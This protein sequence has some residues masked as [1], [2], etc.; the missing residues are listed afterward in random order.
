MKKLF[1]FLIF[2][3]IALNVSAQNCDSLYNEFLTHFTQNHSQLQTDS[4]TEG[5][6]CGFPLIVQISSNFEKFDKKQQ[7]LI[8]NY[9][10]RDE[11][12]TSIISPKGYFKIHFDTSGYYKPAYDILSAAKAFDSV[13][14]YEINILGYPHPPGD[15]ELGGDNRYD[16]YIGGTNDYGYT[17]SD[18]DISNI[19]SASHIVLHHSF[20]KFPTKGLKA[21]Q[22]TAAH[23][24]HHAIQLGN[25]GVENENQFYAEIT[26]TSMEEFV[27]D[28]VND[29][30]FYLPY[31][32][33]TT[34]LPFSSTNNKRQYALG[35]WNI[36]LAEYFRDQDPELGFKIIKGSWENVPGR[37]ALQA[38]EL[39][40]N[41]FGFSFSQ[42]FPVFA[43]WCFFTSYRKIENSFFSEAKNYPII[44]PL[45]VMNFTSGFC[46]TTV[47][48]YPASTLYLAFNDFG[49]SLVAIVS[50][51]DYMKAIQAQNSSAPFTFSL[52]SNYQSGS[53]EI[54]KDK[55]YSKISGIQSN[56]LGQNYV[57][58]N[59]P[60]TS[61]T[62]NLESK[63]FVYPQPFNYSKH[64]VLCFP[65]LKGE[66]PTNHLYIYDLS[67][68]EH[69]SGEIRYYNSDLTLRWNGLNKNGERL[70]SGVYL[71]IIKNGEKT[72]K[73]R[74]VLIND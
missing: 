70:S 31:Y 45:G 56:I 1:S 3:T 68:N 2:F 24:F 42:L 44:K 9:L 54:I 59:L 5:S 67:V 51:T 23:E 25:Y 12:Q 19:S 52:Y 57:F 32:F 64:G 18:F 29:Y 6:K 17:M 73:G 13:Y 20:E 21:A 55:Y 22:V 71:Y 49:D 50:N 34:D 39:S 15:N 7:A 46:E 53:F 62:P 63:E 14:N 60:V 61:E 4:S 38:I 36:F 10:S 66:N 74:F 41:N 65:A 47:Q 33:A 37:N 30:Y 43:N 48:S 40:L 69:Y 26:S 28:D 16:I 72:E 27:Y 8:S 11:K 35:L 58:N